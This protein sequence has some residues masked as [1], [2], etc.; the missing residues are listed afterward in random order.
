MASGHLFRMGGT[1]DAGDIRYSSS[2]TAI[3]MMSG[4]NRTFGIENTGIPVFYETS[5]TIVG[6]AGGASALPA[7]PVRYINVRYNTGTL[8]SPVIATGKVPIFSF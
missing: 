4:G 8:A 5:G 6:G 1:T 3:Q 7:T 2:D